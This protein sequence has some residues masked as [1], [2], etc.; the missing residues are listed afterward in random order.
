MLYTF[1]SLCGH[2]E[3][4]GKSRVSCLSV[5][6]YSCKVSRLSSWQRWPAK[7]MKV[8]I[9]TIRRNTFSE[10]DSRLQACDLFAHTEGG[11]VSLFDK[12]SAGPALLTKTLQTPKKCCQ[13]QASHAQSEAGKQTADQDV[14]EEHCKAITSTNKSSCQ[15]GKQRTLPTPPSSF[16]PT[17]LWS[18]MGLSCELAAACS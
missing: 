2:C 14:P 3:L 7:L 6:I 15:F 5:C 9:C 18:S 11:S 1:S 10:S 4:I 16:G 13:P 12:A 17:S 8:L